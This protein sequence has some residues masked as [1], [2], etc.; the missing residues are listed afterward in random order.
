MKVR[1]EN[2]LPQISWKEILS[3]LEDGVIT[4]DLEGKIAFFN[5]PAEVLTGIS[6]SR[7]LQHSFIRLFK[8]EPWL[9]ELLKK[10]GPPR[11][12]N[13]RAEGDILTRSGRKVPIAA[14]ASPLQDASGN[15]LGNILLIRDLAYRKEL[16]EDLKRADR[17]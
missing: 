12:E 14:A 15:F 4:V 1:N 11:H 2:S 5:E 17:L 6:A 7:A 10:S 16:E 8:Q 13:V 9:L 3:S